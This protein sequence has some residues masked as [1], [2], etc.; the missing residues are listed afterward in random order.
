MTN[1]EYYKEEFLDIAKRG[2]DPVV[3]IEG[4]VQSCAEISCNKCVWMNDLVGCNA[5]RYIWGYSEYVP[6]TEIDAK[7][8][9]NVLTEE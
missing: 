2:Y 6:K 9:N 7:A 8:L 3:T 1:F 5:A 4:K